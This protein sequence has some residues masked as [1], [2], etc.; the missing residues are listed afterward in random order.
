VATELR[1]KQT[2]QIRQKKQKRFVLWQRAGRKL[3]AA[4]PH[5]RCADTFICLFFLSRKEAA[6]QRAQPNFIAYYELEKQEKKGE[7]FFY[8][9]SRISLQL[10]LHS[11][12]KKN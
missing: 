5:Q 7:I 6:C 12:I 2:S 9:S 8:T 11:E 3:P 1:V 4:I 10:L